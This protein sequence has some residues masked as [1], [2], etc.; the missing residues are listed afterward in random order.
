VSIDDMEGAEWNTEAVGPTKRVRATQLIQRLKNRFAPGGLLHFGQGKWYPGESLP[1]WSLNCIW[2]KDG[3]SVWSDS[4]LFASPDVSNGQG[5]V[6][7][8]MFA[9]ELAE[10]L[11]VSTQ[12]VIPAFEDAWYYM[13]R[14][15]RL[16]ANV[17]VR[18]SRLEDAEERA[19]IARVFEQGLSSP[20]G[21][22]LPLRRSGWGSERHW[23]SGPWVVRS[24]ELYLVPGDS[25]MGFRLPLQSLVWETTGT[26]PLMFRMDPTIR[27]DALPSYDDML[28]RQLQS[29]TGMAGIPRTRWAQV[30]QYSGMPTD[31]SAR[32]QTLETARAGGNGRWTAMDKPSGNGHYPEG[33]LPIEDEDDASGVFTVPVGQNPSIVRTALCVEPRG[34]VLH[35][36]MPPVELLEDYL[37][38]VVAIEATAANQSQR[39]VIEGYLPPE[40]SRIQHIKVTPDPGVIEVNVHPAAN[41]DELVQITTG[42]YEDAHYSRLG[43]EKFHRDGRHTGTGGGNHVVLGGATPGDSPWLRRPDLLKSFV[44]YWHNH[45]SLSYLFSSTFIG[46]TSQAPRVDEG[47]RDAVYELKIALEQ[48]PDEGKAPPWL[49]DRVFRHLL[50]DGTGNTHRA[51]FCIDK[52]FSP[53]SS[54]RRLGLLELRGFEMPPHHR[55]SMAQM[56]LIRALVVAFWE[57][58]YDQPLM[59]WGTSLH[60]R[61]LLPYPVWADFGQVIDDL[62]DRGIAIE[63]RWFE[64]HFEFRFPFIGAVEQRDMRLEL[65]TAIEPWYVLGEEPGGGGTVRY[66]DSSIERLQVR[67]DGLTSPR[68]QVTCNG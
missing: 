43:T 41:W 24:D 63:Q 9:L 46:P 68:Y 58:P 11:Y 30:L 49:V 53:D 27:R 31:R 32:M 39:V 23:E 61:Y 26:A 48:I 8:K 67:F 28:Q 42:V 25:P 2:R 5:F 18:D 35:V 38:L 36:F 33:V 56:L 6:E 19:R 14:E 55:M 21:C 62:I 37:D 4:T 17:D 65:R 13:W 66:V 44:A 40:D 45:P 16:P 54:S 47:R 15:R 50:V 60:D 22:L 10:R 29:R 20:V 34:G 7:A 3:Q 57:R 1:R 52:L 59:E 12:H 51:E 64:P